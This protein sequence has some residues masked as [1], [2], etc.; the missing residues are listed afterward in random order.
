MADVRK[1]FVAFLKN[2][3]IKYLVQIVVALALSLA[4]MG[5]RGAFDAGA[6]PAD[7]AKAVCDGFSI[8]AMI[9][10]CFGILMWISTTGFFDIFA[11]AFRKGAH[12]I[13]P[14]M[15][16]DNSMNSYYDY[17]Q[18]KMDKRKSRPMYS[19]LVIGILFFIISMALVMYWYSL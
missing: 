1:K 18:D 14:G 16:L 11:Y 8:T 5:F 7:R 6:M 17:K 2:N 12:A 10:I 15:G 9:Y 13:I 19:T 3:W 4:F